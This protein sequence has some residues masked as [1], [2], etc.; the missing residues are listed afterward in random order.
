MK[1]RNIIQRKKN[2]NVGIERE[3]IYYRK[4]NKT[5]GT[6]GKRERK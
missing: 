6:S 3:G 5:E 1:T 2:R 4:S